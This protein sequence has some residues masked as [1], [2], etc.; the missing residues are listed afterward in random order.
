M[1]LSLTR[2]K[3]EKWKPSKVAALPNLNPPGF[4]FIRVEN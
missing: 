3:R 2:L 1:K 4:F